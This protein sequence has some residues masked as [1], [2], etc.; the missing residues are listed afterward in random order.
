[1]WNPRS[2]RRKFCGR[3]PALQADEIKCL[4]LPFCYRNVVDYYKIRNQNDWKKKSAKANLDDMAKKKWRTLPKTM[5]SEY[6]EELKKLNDKY[7]D[8]YAK[9]LQVSNFGNS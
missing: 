9:F 3:V 5:K 2:H 8:D 1:M 4:S 6:V 7:L